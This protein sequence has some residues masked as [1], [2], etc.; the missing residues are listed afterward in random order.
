[1]LGASTPVAAT[2]AAHPPLAVRETLRI[3]R[4]AFEGHAHQVYGDLLG[5]D[6]ARI[7]ELTESGVI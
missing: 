1:M 3:G 4:R 7:A 6:D 2:I 5:L